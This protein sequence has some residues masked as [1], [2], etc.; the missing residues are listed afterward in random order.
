MSLR[1]FIIL[2]SFICVNLSHGYGLDEKII[3]RIIENELELL[4]IENQSEERKL[5]DSLIQFFSGNKSN[6][7]KNNFIENLKKK[8]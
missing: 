5:F 3:K 2:S 6:N 1:V 8:S 4:E 7:I